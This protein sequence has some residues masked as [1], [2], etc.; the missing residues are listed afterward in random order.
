MTLPT[1]EQVTNIYLYGQETVPTDMTSSSVANTDERTPVVVNIQEYM[2][3]GAG[4]FVSAYSFDFLHEFFNP[5]S[6]GALSLAPGT[7]TKQQLF[8]ALGI[9]NEDN[10]VTFNNVFY[11]VGDSDYAE[12]TYIWGTVGFAVGNEALFIVDTNG[13]RHVEN[14]SIVPLST[15]PGRDDENFDFA[16]G[17]WSSIGNG[18]LGLYDTIDPSRIGKTVTFEFSGD[19]AKVSLYQ[20]QFNDL[21][22]YVI[23]PSLPNAEKIWEL[24]DSLFAVGSTRFLYDD[25][26]II[27]GTSGS[28]LM[29]G[30]SGNDTLIAGMGM[31]TLNGGEGADIYQL[32]LGD[33]DNVFIKDDT[34]GGTIS[35]LNGITFRRVGEGG[36]NTNGLYIA[37]DANGDWQN[38]KEGWSVSVSGS[39]A[40]VFVKDGDSKQ[41][42]IAIENFNISSNHF[43]IQFDKM[44]TGAA[45][46]QT[47]V[48]TVGD[49]KD[50]LQQKLDAA[51]DDP[52]ANRSLIYNAADY[53]YHYGVEMDDGQVIGPDEDP[54]VITCLFE[55]SD[56]ADVLNG[57]YWLPTQLEN[58]NDGL[59]LNRVDLLHF[60]GYYT[61]ESAGWVGDLI[62]DMRL[63]A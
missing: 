27:Y 16:G 48:Y 5:E 39:T 57:S 6:S 47:N 31:D 10:S 45:P 61:E 40:T 26:P 7:Y 42:V 62:D 3:V 32:A 50:F 33:F 13:T 9:D 35:L 14:F 19:V 54:A 56:Q 4:R 43:G 37:V 2:T 12:R 63:A 55:G 22:D 58:A 8:A 25:K 29:L 59:T 36:A 46:T 49:G 24:T 44:P 20:E 11:G 1:A 51:P 60:A 41:H 15:L 52:F 21:A 23:E 28:D 17:F 38:G 53:E 30:G 34:D 18:L